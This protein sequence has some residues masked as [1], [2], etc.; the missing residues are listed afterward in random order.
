MR[1]GFGQLGYMNEGIEGSGTRMSSNCQGSL[2]SS[3]NRRNKRY[4]RHHSALAVK[5]IGIA[6]LPVLKNLDDCFQ[7]VVMFEV[8]VALQSCS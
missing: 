5:I 7:K 3:G 1:N 8:S 2:R 6:P 4:R